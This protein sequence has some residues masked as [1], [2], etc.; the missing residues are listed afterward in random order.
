M[1]ISTGVRGNCKYISY[2]WSLLCPFGSFYPSLEVPRR[3]WWHLKGLATVSYAC[4]K[5]FRIFNWSFSRAIFPG[6]FVQYTSCSNNISRSHSHRLLFVLGGSISS[7]KCLLISHHRT[8]NAALPEFPADWDRAILKTSYEIWT[9][10]VLLLSLV[11]GVERL[12]RSAPDAPRSDD[13]LTG[14][15]GC[16]ANL[17]W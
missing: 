9:K 17:F 8:L 12:S 1:R 10:G 16:W 15:F 2:L 13:F 7:L 4:V 11:L 5:R 3:F 6:N 14:D